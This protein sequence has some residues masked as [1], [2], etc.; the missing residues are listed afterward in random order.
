LGTPNSN[1][2][3]GNSGSL[4]VSVSGTLSGGASTPSTVTSSTGT[5]TGHNNM[6][7][8]TVAN[9]IIKL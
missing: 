9:N 8:F 7:P 6:Q 5:N 3:T 4:G 1:E 2:R